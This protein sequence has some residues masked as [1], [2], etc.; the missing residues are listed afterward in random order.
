MIH[1]SW[2]AASITI[3]TTAALLKSY[4]CIEK[5]SSIRSYMFVKAMLRQFFDGI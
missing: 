3:I 5:S 4:T 2:L 1:G